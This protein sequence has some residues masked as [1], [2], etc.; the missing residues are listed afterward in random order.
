MR[1]LIAD[2]EAL[3]RMGLRTMLRDMGHDVV[4]AAVDGPTALQ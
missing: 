1:V 4:G 3:T 2:D